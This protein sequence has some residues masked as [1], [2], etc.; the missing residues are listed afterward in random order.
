[1]MNVSSIGGGSIGRVE[2]RGNPERTVPTPQPSQASVARGED[3]VELSEHARFLARMRELPEIRQDLVD[4]IK[5]E[6]EAGT[7]D[8]ADKLDQAIEGILDDI[9]Q[10][11]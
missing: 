9:E 7:Y 5:A 4:R 1:M 3:Q 10:G 2:P 8:T 6:I 11:L